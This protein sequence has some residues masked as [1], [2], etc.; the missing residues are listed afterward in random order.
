MDNAILDVRLREYRIDGIGKPGQMIYTGDESIVY[1]SVPEAAEHRRP[2]L[3][4]LILSNPHAQDVFV[5]FQINANSD[6]DI[7]PN[8]G[9]DSV[10]ILLMV[11]SDTSTHR[12]HGYRFRYPMLSSLLHTWAEISSQCPD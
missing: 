7:F 6:V 10:L 8:D 12:C 3:G 5:V 11:V 1:S 2:V 4:A 9:K